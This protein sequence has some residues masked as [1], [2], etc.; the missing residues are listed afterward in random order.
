MMSGGKKVC[1]SCFTPRSKTLHSPS[2]HS[3]RSRRRSAL[4]P[5]ALPP[6]AP[7]PNTLHRVVC[8]SRLRLRRHPSLCRSSLPPFVGP[9]GQ[10]PLVELQLVPLGEQRYPGSSPHRPAVAIHEATIPSTERRTATRSHHL[11]EQNSDR[12]PSRSVKYVDTRQ[13]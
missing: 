3:R 2:L 1:T 12:S 13:D 8:H 9:H 5:I 10:P 7:P 4:P 6:F 11:V